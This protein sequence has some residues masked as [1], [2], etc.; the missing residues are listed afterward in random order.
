MGNAKGE[1][2][3]AGAGFSKKRVAACKDISGKLLIV[4]LY[5]AFRLGVNIAI[6]NIITAFSLFP[7]YIKA[8]IYPDIVKTREN[9]KEKH[10][11]WL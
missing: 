11:A 2:L 7:L 4:R 5:D 8:K 1:K 6:T 10:L 9:S 3:R